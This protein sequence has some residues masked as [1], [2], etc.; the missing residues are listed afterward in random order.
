VA[1]P[2][3]ISPANAGSDAAIGLQ[4]TVL[5]SLSAVD[6]TLFGLVVAATTRRAGFALVA[7]F[8]LAG[9]VVLRGVT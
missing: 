3:P 8:P 9:H 7:L 5:K 2:L 4:Q 1:P 6:P